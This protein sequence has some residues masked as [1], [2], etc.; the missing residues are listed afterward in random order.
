MSAPSPAPAA[1]ERDRGEAFCALADEAIRSGTLSA[2]PDEALQRVFAAAVKL[3]AA[4]CEERGA[5][6]PPFGERPVNATETVT[7][8]CALMR[9]ADLNF[10]DLAMWY[11][12]GPE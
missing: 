6:F 12:R 1:I 3:Y 4:K 9:A 10:F 7:A 5:E 2:V 11:R 8:I